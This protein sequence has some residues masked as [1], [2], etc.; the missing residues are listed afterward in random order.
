VGPRPLPVPEAEGLPPAWRAWR[1][2]VKPGVFSQWAFSKEKHHTL[3]RWQELEEATVVKGGVGEDLKQI[4]LSIKAILLSFF[5][6]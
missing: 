4:L 1:E 6:R 5:N 3:K 2:Q